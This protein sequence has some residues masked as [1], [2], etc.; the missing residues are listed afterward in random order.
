MST[1]RP[2]DESGAPMTRDDRP[3]VVRDDG[4]VVDADGRTIDPAAENGR[5][6]RG[7]PGPDGRLIEEPA[8][9]DAADDGP[10]LVAGRHTVVDDDAVMSADPVARERA[11]YGGI[12]WGSA[13]FGWL[14]AMGVAVLL[15]S[16]LVGAGTAVG[17][18]TPAT[19]TEAV[20]TAQGIGWA[21]LAAVLAVMFVAYLAGGYVAGRMARFDGARQGLGVW[22]WAVVIV[23]VVAAVASV[24][25]ARYDVLSQLNSFPRIPVDAGTLTT[26]GVISLVA[27]AL[28]SLIGAV[29][30]GV[31][32]M[33]YHRRVDAVG[34][35]SPVRTA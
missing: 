28:V 27:A 20:D 23:L 7:R 11:A 18:Q 3:R 29:L 26:W 6:V 13:F 19:T 17:V 35:G 15:T 14:S 21:G 8:P 16:L 30:G 4:T 22:V 24:A 1:M 9:T 2:G 34:L 12:K 10:R 25:G 31:L 5:V 33:R 32:G